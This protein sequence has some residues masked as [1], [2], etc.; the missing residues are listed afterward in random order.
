MHQRDLQKLEGVLSPS[1]LQVRPFKFYLLKSVNVHFLWYCAAINIFVGNGICPFSTAKQSE[2]Q[3]MSG[4]L[5]LN[6]LNFFMHAELMHLYNLQHT[7]LVC[8]TRIISECNL[9]EGFG[10]VFY[11]VAYSGS[12]MGY[13]CTFLL[14]TWGLGGYIT[15]MKYELWSTN[16]FDGVISLITNH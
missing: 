10:L 1:H 11:F 13:F 8:I 3:D 5:L 9:C 14:G 16:T 7:L 15:S 12:Y 4:T 2:H 6:W